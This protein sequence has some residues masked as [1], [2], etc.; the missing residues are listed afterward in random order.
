MKS[1]GRGKSLERLQFQKATANTLNSVF[2]IHQKYEPLLKFFKKQQK[3][4]RS[5][6]RSFLQSTNKKVLSAKSAGRN[7][8]KVH[9]VK[10]IN[11]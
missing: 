7:V 1:S 9:Y 11:K 2:C 6:A 10:K 4:L 8:N 5:H 3:R